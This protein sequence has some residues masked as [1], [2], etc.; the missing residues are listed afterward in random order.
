MVQP[1][2]ESRFDYKGFPCAVL[3][4]SGCYRCGYVGI[5]KDNKWYK[6]DMGEIPVDCHGGITYAD[7]K[8]YHQNDKDKWWIG[9][10]CAH[11]FDGYDLE[12]AEKYFGS[13]EKWE[14]QF[15]LMRDYYITMNEEHRAQT[16]EDCKEECRQIVE[17]LLKESEE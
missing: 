4:M 13:D 1:V 17:Q 5:P 6:K 16:L 15:S 2:L 7:S 10:D 8:L 3:F 9:F 12:T 14:K 11:C